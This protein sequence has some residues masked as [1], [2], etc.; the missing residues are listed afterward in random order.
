MPVP[1]SELAMIATVEKS[2]GVHEAVA[3]YK[4]L[5]DVERGFRQLKDVWHCGRSTIKSN[6]ASEHIS[7]LLRWHCWFSGSSTGVC[8]RPA[9]SF[10]STPRRL[11][12]H[13]TTRRVSSGR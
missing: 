1:E 3:I 4:D 9:S 12:V 2:L 10:P 8:E 11:F 13:G 7:S 5:A 6:H